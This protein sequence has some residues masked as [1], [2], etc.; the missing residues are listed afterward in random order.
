MPGLT[1]EKEIK[2]DNQEVLIFFTVKKFSF[3]SSNQP[4][5]CR[6]EKNNLS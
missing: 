2:I 4:L 1:T 6:Y 3:F 5:Y